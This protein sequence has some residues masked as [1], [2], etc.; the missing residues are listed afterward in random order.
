MNSVWTALRFSSRGVT[1]LQ[2]SM[3]K[4]NKSHHYKQTLL[5]SRTY[6]SVSTRSMFRDRLRRALG[7]LDMLSISQAMRRDASLVPVASPRTPRRKVSDSEHWEC[8]LLG[9]GT[10]CRR[11]SGVW[12]EWSGDTNLVA[13]CLGLGVSLSARSAGR[14][15]G[16]DYVSTKDGDGD[17]A[18][19]TEE[20]KGGGRETCGSCK[21][22]LGSD[23]RSIV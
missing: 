15:A 18:R 2:C 1:L 22:C 5:H 6:L 14:Q 3:E 16:R 23:V 19:W 21:L 4:K 12:S 13:P 17:S 8:A 11:W 9:H 7:K 10:S 20:R